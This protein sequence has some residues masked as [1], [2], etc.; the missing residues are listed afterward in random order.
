MFLIAAQTLADLVQE[1][2]LADGT[3]YPRLNEIRKASLAIAVAVARRAY[4][5]GLALAPKPKDLEKHIADLVY[6]PHY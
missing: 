3:M 5:K 2:D 1:K 4:D 6:D